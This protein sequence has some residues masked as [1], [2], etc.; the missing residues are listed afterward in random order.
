V[1]AV[2]NTITA[3]QYHA[4]ARGRQRVK[5]HC[6]VS[7]AFLEIGRLWKQAPRLASRAT[8]IFRCPP[9]RGG[10]ETNV[11]DR[12][13]GI[14]LY[15]NLLTADIPIYRQAKAEYSRLD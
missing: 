15:E 13:F 8:G 6:L 5:F 1:A 3:A 12:V 9:N 10:S 14:G 2:R 11:D 7:G 4:D